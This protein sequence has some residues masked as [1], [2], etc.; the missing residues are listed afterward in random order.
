MQEEKQQLE[1]E[2]ENAKKVSEAT[3]NGVSKANNHPSTDKSKKVNGNHAGLNGHQNGNG[4]VSDDEDVVQ[5]K[6]KLE[7]YKQVSL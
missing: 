4:H 7:T 5:L 1:K 3:T 2:L 6:Q